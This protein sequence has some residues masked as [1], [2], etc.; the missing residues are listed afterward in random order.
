M[1]LVCAQSAAL[2]HRAGA[3]QDLSLVEAPNMVIF[4]YFCMFVTGADA[5]SLHTHGAGRF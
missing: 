4:E 3:K 1:A 2:Q 5:L